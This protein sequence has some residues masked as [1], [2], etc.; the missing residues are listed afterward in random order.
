MYKPL[1]F[2]HSPVRS[3]HFQYPAILISVNSAVSIL[4]LILKQLVP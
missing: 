3:D 4:T 1:A 2:L